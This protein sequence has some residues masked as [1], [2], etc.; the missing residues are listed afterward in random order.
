M[1]SQSDPKASKKRAGRKRLPPL[2]PGPALQFVVAS[3]PDDFKADETMRNVRSHVMYKHRGE[4]RGVS[5]RDRSK[6]GERSNRRIAG[7]RTPSPMTTNSDGILEDDNIFPEGNSF[8]A[9]P[10]RRST[11]WDGQFIQLMSQSAQM[12]PVRDLAARIISACTAE[13]ARSAPPTFH[14]GSEFPFPSGSAIA[15][16]SLQDLKAVYVEGGEFCQNRVWMETV[17]STRMSFLSHVSATCVYQ[18]VAEGYLEDSAL[19][20]YA[21]TKVLRMIKDSLQ[22]FNTQ[23]DDFIILSILYLLVSEIG[24][25]DEDVF[26][27]HQQG[28]VRII[29]QR[30]GIGNLGQGGDIATFLI[31]VI[32]SFTILRGQAEPTM[33]HGYVPSRRQSTTLQRSLPVSPLY[34]PHGDLSPMYGLCT[35][36]TY[37]ILCDMH[38]LTRTFVARWTYV[39]GSST[40]LASYDAHMQQIY[41][42]LLLRPS[43]DDDI[44]AD[45]VYESC[46]LAALIYC[47]SIVQGMPLSDSANTIHARSSGADISG[48]TMISALHNA[49]ENT[50]KSG[51]WG[52]M[53]GVFLWI[54]LVGG[55]GSW[56]SSQLVFGERDDLHTSSAWVRKCFALLAVKS[57]L[58]HGFEHAGAVVEAQRT[59][60]Q[61]QSL[62]NLKRGIASQ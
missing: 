6:S 29:H 22:G 48:I 8:L 45:W 62:I 39:G 11:V 18:D 44:T 55:A 23:S 41:T 26:D 53:C 43:T 21:K 32:L 12:G 40:D 35:D 36:A 34:A 42:T 30:G 16:E 1:T 19:T 14:Q 49:L 7:T 33:L 38:E 15:Q 25:F 2:A 51:L 59:M 60:L 5:P 46:R 13:P 52:D 27:V 10:R 50:D 20:V 47:R 4:Q 24:G 3:H 28:L 37:E 54:C 56:P 58:S 57:S 17:C 9:P 31:L 61:V